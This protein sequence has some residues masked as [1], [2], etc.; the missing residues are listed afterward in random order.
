MDSLT[1]FTI[2]PSFTSQSAMANPDYA[3]S[4]SF[5]PA[6]CWSWHSNICIQNIS[7]FSNSFQQINNPY[8]YLI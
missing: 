2:S 4:G 7:S 6:S 1:S 5:R 3:T 8:F